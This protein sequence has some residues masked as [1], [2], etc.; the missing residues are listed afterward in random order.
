MVAPGPPPSP[1]SRCRSAPSQPLPR[2]RLWLWQ[3]PQQAHGPCRVLWLCAL[4]TLC[5]GDVQRPQEADSV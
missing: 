1:G 2:K 4:N 3:L 5:A